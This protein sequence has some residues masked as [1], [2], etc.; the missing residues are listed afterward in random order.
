MVRSGREL[1]EM[2]YIVRADEH[3]DHSLANLRDHEQ[4]YLQ[5]REIFRT[6][7]TREHF[8]LPRQHALFHF[9]HNIEDFGSANGVC[10]TLSESKHKTAIKEP[11]RRTNQNA[12]IRQMLTI[13]TRMDQLAAC[14][15][16]FTMRGL[17]QKD[18]LWAVM[19]DLGLLDDIRDP[20][21][22]NAALPFANAADSDAED[23]DDDEREEAAASGDGEQ[24][25]GRDDEGAV[26]GPRITSSVKMS[27]RPGRVL[28]VVLAHSLTGLA[29][30]I[31]LSSS[32][33]TTWRTYTRAYACSACVRLS[34]QATRTRN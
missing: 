5:Y 11:W 1:L 20:A 21:A 2:L 3:D 16:I 4:L 7:G 32:A 15:V 6:T 23:D 18:C 19:S 30:S 9:R 10:T 31:G 12:P 25:A 28:S 8:N 29:L 24:S 26:D 22:A 13:N 27:R 14:K 17:L 34:L 33:G